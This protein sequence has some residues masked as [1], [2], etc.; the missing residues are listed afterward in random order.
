MEPLL[1]IPELSAL[2]LAAL[3]IEERAARE[4]RLLAAI[5][6]MRLFLVAPPELRGDLAGMMQ[7]FV[8]NLEQLWSEASAPKDVQKFL[9]DLRR[10]WP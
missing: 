7:A 1:D 6:I 5:P 10:H 2:Q 4:A 8:R 9:A 3:S